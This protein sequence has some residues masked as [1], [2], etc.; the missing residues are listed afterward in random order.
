MRKNVREV[1]EAWNENRKCDPKGAGT[2]WTDGDV[3]YSYSTAI[4]ADVGDGR[5][6]LNL[7]KYSATTSQHQSGIRG[8]LNA[9]GGVIL[10]NLVEVDG[11]RQGATPVELRD[12]AGKMAAKGIEVGEEKEEEPEPLDFEADPALFADYDE[13]AGF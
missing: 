5:Y 6:Y 8:W 10:E 3:V 1:M 11:V 13:R 2:V 7:T 4:L 9:R 12:R